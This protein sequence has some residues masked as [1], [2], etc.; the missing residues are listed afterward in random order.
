MIGISCAMGALNPG[1]PS[2]PGWQASLSSNNW[3]YSLLD[4]PYSQDLSDSLLYAAEVWGVHFFKF[5][6]AD[7]AAAVPGDPRPFETRYALG[8]ERFVEMV[9][10]LKRSVPDSHHHCSLRLCPTRL[11]RTPGSWGAAPCG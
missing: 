11:C 6:F 2:V 1:N 10:R 8:V 7:F 4:G 5:D 9:A 3:N